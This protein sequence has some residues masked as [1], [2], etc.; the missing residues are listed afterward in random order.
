MK[1]WTK[2]ALATALGA[3]GAYLLPGRDDHTPAEPMDLPDDAR[4]SV[5]TGSSMP[6]WAQIAIGAATGA[7]STRSLPGAAAIGLT[8]IAL[9]EATVTVSQGGVR[10]DSGLPGIGYT[11]APERIRS[12]RAVTVTAA[13]FGGLGFR[14]SLTRGWGLILRPG[15]ALVL[16]L[17][18]GKFTVTV[19]DD[20]A[21]AGLINAVV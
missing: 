20:E 11:F 14:W 9:R 12:A 3:A 2:V 5:S 18:N 4:A 8:T 21:A 19:D 16:E 15:A 7:L 10:I 6:A 17:N 13:E 1:N